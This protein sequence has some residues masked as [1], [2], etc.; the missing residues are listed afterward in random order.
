MKNRLHDKKAGIV[1]LAILFFVSLTDVIMRATAFSEIASATNNHGEAM[2]TLIFS[3][4]LLVFALKGKDRVFHIL[5]G[6]W[7][8][9]FVLNQLYGL[10]SMIQTLVYCISTANIFG[11]IA[12]IAHAITIVSIIAIGALLV[13]YM[14]D[15]TI[16]NKAFN[17]LCIITVLVQGFLLLHTMHSTFNYGNTNVILAVLHEESRLVMVFLFTFFAYDSAKSQLKKTVFTK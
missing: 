3:A 6:V 2:I 8:G 5:C 13:E 12:A 9:Y 15:G 17:I 11:T 7:L 10:P 1:I 14:N 16:Y 4:L